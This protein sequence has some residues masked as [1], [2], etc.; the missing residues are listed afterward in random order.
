M[1][2]YS[3]KQFD[4]R[5]TREVVPHHF[6][7][8]SNQEFSLMV[9]QARANFSLILEEVLT[10]MSCE[11]YSKSKAYDLGMWLIANHNIQQRGEVPLTK[12]V[13]MEELNLDDVSFRDA[14]RKLSARILKWH[15]L[16]FFSKEAA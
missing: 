8:T 13:I 15:N 4:G 16:A 2:T 1:E 6:Q 5:M 12:K 9:A 7:G 11:G 3:V 10:I 14:Q